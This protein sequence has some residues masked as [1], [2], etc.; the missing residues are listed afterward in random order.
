VFVGIGTIL[1]DRI[2]SAKCTVVL[3]AGL[4]YGKPP[5]IN[6]DWRVYGVRGPATAQVLRLNFN[7]VL[8]DPAIL[9]PLVLGADAPPML[10]EASFMPHH[11]SKRLG[12][13]RAICEQAG[14]HYLD[15]AQDIQDLVNEMRASQRV[16]CEAMHGAIVADAYRIPWVPV[17]CYDH[18]LPFKWVDWCKSLSLEYQPVQLPCIYNVRTNVSFTKKIKSEGKRMLR[19]ADIA[20]KRWSP[21]LPR[22]TGAS[23]EALAVSQ[24]AQLR[25]QGTVYL[26]SNEAHEQ[27]LARVQGALA[28]LQEDLAA[29]RV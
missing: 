7:L 22:M 6:A 21:P 26:S 4:G 2:P 1:N 9:L 11:A 25:T 29:G 20:P 5:Q 19:S 12:N 24:L 23:E 17:V 8:T 10:Y 14:V 13:W 27:A 3:G 16:I 28:R 18:I 15:P